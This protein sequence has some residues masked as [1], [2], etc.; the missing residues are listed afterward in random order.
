MDNQDLRYAAETMQAAA[1]G[2]QIQWRELY[3]E[4]SIWSDAFDIKSCAWNW[5]KYLYRIKPEP[6]ECW[7]VVYADTRKIYSLRPTLEN[8]QRILKTLKALK[9]TYSIIRLVE[10]EEIVKED[11]EEI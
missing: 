3:K 9:Q 11:K 1:E 4:T 10:A 5:G 7:A 6:L 8:A 2:K